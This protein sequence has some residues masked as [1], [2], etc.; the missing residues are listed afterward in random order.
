MDELRFNIESI[1]YK[2]YES[3][4]FLSQRLLRELMTKEAILKVLKACQIEF[5]IIDEISKII[6]DGAW[7]T[8]AILVLIEKPNLIT[9]F[10]E[11][12]FGT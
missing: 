1:Q 3:R 8:F 7:K 11:H 2:N 9:Q 6:Y 10:I 4:R 5:Y 12:S